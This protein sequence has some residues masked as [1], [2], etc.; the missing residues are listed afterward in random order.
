MLNHYYTVVR[1]K[2]NAMSWK[3]ITN[4][5]ILQSEGMQSDEGTYRV[6]LVEPDPNNRAS[7]RTRIVTKAVS[8]LLWD[9]DSDEQ[10]QNHHQLFK[11]L[12]LHPNA[13][14][15]LSY[16]YEPAF[17][18]LCVRG[19]TFRIY[20]IADSRQSGPVNYKFMNDQRDHS[21]SELLALR[22][23]TRISVNK[24]RPIDSLRDNCYYRPTTPNHPSYDSLI[25]NDN[26]HRI[27]VFK[28][29]VAAEHDL[30]PKEVRELAEL[31]Q[32][33]HIS[34]LKI[35]II[36]VV[37]E[38]AQVTYKIEKSLFDGLGLEVYFLQVTEHQL[39]PF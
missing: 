23:S 37:Y 28:V 39:Y 9:R 16:L 11:T 7:R 2:V 5:L 32:R 24:D 34:N 17:H 30:V 21:K 14:S 19:A 13:K 38:D 35:R 10:W 33:L 12:L 18:G 20:S 4:I 27:S 3:I 36:V 31:G 25:Y 8:Q 29:A 6:L 1:R 15:F 22:A 26:S